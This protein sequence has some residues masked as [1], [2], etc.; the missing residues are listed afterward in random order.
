[1]LVRS[2]LNQAILP[3]SRLKMEIPG[4]LFDARRAQSI[5]SDPKIKW[6]AL[7]MRGIG[8]MVVLAATIAGVAHAAG[9][10]RMAAQVL[11]RQA[12]V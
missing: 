11:G 4:Q 12:D 5:S 1:M 6:P 9:V 7:G 2:C 8:I 3:D 10:R